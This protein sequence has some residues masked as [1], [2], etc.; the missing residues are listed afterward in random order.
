MASEPQ[1]RR[2]VIGDLPGI[3]DL[4]NHYVAHTPVSFEVAAV[5][6]EDRLEWLNEHSG[7]G[8][9]RLL[10]A[11]DETGSVRGWATTSPFRPRA[12]YRTTVE[13]SVYLRPDSLGHGLGSRLYA[14]L[15]DSIQGQDLERIVAGVTLPNPASLALHAKLGFRP[16]GTFTRVGRKFGQFWDVEWFERPLHLAAGPG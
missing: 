5:R 4:Y 10:V 13:S 11:A 8:P 15:F 16:V 9:Y 2:G 3:V 1:V 7:A 14:S 12:A 6:P